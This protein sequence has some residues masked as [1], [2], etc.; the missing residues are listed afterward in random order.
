MSAR[1]KS[2][3]R[4]AI[5]TDRRSH[6]RAGRGSSGLE[7]QDFRE[8]I[9]TLESEI[10]RLKE[11]KRSLEK[12]NAALLSENERLQDKCTH[13]QKRYW[14]VDEEVNDLRGLLS[15]RDARIAELEKEVAQKDARIKELL[16]KLTGNVPKSEKGPLD[17]SGEKKKPQRKRRRGRQEGAPGS[18][19]NKN[20]NL[21]VDD[22]ITR[23][24]S[25]SEKV[26]PDC[27]ELFDEV[28]SEESYEVEIEVR[29]YRR[30][31]RRKKYGH[32]CKTRKQWLT[33]TAPP[34][35]KIWPKAG[36]GITVWV[37][38]LLGK[39]LFQL[40]MY[41]LCMQ[42]LMYGIRI[43]EGTIVA[44]FMRIEKYIDSLIDEIKRYS[45]D[46]KKHWHIDDT[47][48]KVF[49]LI[50]GKKGYGWYLWVFL[51]ND[52]CVYIISPS[53]GR[54]V[55][56]SHLE[57]SVGIATSDRLASN[58]KLGENVIN[59]F[60]W[61]HIRRE[62][63]EL[64]AAYP[65]I[66]NEC[67]KLLALIGSL[68]H[69]NKARLLSDEGSDGYMKAQARLGETLD[70]IESECRSQLLNPNLHP[71]L[72][73]L[74]TGVLKDWDGLRLFFDFPAI[75]PDNNPAER[76][77]RRYVA[78]RK[79]Y[80]GSGSQASARFT[81]KMFTLIETLKLNKINPKEFLT[82]YFTACAVNGGKAPPNAKNFLPWNRKSAQ[83]AG[84]PP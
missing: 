27:G 80:Y 71:E 56:Q 14:C 67:E 77:L 13:Y 79:S 74:F 73:R 16:A 26:C 65:E 22:E 43:S 48:W 63:R 82:E 32:F 59:S 54:A 70:Q 29:G 15:L 41:R 37:F 46:E 61:V 58:M 25:D 38:L 57:N 83:N 24:I 11:E 33:K 75:P 68:Y 49:V 78:G 6:Q 60:C 64:A 45:R 40:P 31:H 30:R 42:L 19:R 18:G 47:G 34:S 4:P 28:G 23:D 3:A 9:K 69:F 10:K 35:P 21:P 20:E 5:K 36:F 81:A 51:S 53:R 39:F 17:K 62:L 72:I 76:A 8:K 66:A 50:D 2:I 52:V 12:E 44:G 84:L 55:P 1:K 7:L